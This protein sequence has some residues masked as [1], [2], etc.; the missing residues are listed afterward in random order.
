[1]ARGHGADRRGGRGEP[2]VHAGQARKE[3][4]GGGGAGGTGAYQELASFAPLT[5]DASPLDGRGEGITLSPFQPVAETRREPRRRGLAL[6][7]VVER[8]EADPALDQLL[9]VPGG[10]DHDGNGRP[11]E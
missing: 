3:G 2:Q 10:K 5:P 4:A 9:L 11:G 6:D 7:Q 8:A 1:R